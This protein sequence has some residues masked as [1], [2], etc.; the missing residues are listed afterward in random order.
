VYLAIATIFKSAA[1]PGYVAIL[2]SG[3]ADT[4]VRDFFFSYAVFHNLHVPESHRRC[5]VA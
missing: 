2:I 3:V 1:G 4:T 5:S